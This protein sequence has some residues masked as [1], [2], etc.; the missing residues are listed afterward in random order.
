MKS[1]NRRQ[2]KGCESEGGENKIE[3]NKNKI[4][5]QRKSREFF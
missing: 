2:R 1:R 4:K 3:E 5:G